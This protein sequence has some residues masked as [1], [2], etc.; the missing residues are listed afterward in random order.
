MVGYSRLIELDEAGTLSRQKQHMIELIKPSIE[1]HS[2]TIVKLTGDG[3]IAEF[4]SVVEAVQCAVEVQ[5]EMLLREENQPEDVRI[6][7]RTAVNLGDIVYEDGDIFGDG[8]NIAARLEELAE[9]GGVVVSG[10][11][12]DLL[13][14]NIDTG[15]VSLGTKRLKNISAPVRVYQ[16]LAGNSSKKAAT[17]PMRPALGA[18]AL[19]AVLAGSIWYF[20]E[21]IGTEERRAI[22]DKP[23]LVVL[24]LDNMTEDTS[25]N[26]FA[27]G[28]SEDLT[29]DLSRH[30]SLFV[31]ARNSAFSTA[32]MFNDPIDAAR[33][34]NVSY[35]VEGS[36]RRVGETLR[37]NVQLIDSK[38]G[39][40]VWAKRYDGTPEDVLKFME[41]VSDEVLVALEI[42]DEEVSAKPLSGQTD[43]PRAFDAFLEGREHFLRQTPE[44]F[45]EAVSLFKRALELDPDYGQARA[46][47]AL[48]YLQ[49][50]EKR[51]H[52]PLGYEYVE[53]RLAMREAQTQVDI[54]MKNPTGLAHQVQAHLFRVNGRPADMLR[55]AQAA[56]EFEPGNPES[57][58]ALSLALTLNGQPNEALGAIE[59]AMNLNPHYPA[60]Y[61]FYQGVALF[62]LKRYEDALVKLER[63]IARNPVDP[64]PFHWK[65]ATHAKMGNL[66]EAEQARRSNPNKQTVYSL[67]LYFPYVSE[68][69]WEHLAEGLRLAGYS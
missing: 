58:A 25:Q 6:H 63:A 14:N 44:D 29:T 57:H 35:V 23:S 47:L 24:P 38:S 1:R 21:P 11:A 49:A 56:V 10:T 64:V 34:L 51:W 43:N 22:T 50:A 54:A 36:V 48:T 26:W 5:K 67:R 53:S 18:L 15:Y 60:Y 13:K 12:Y 66:A 62:D 4:S 55:E 41:S 52:Q 37:I 20:L 39:G 69:T 28:L 7:Y 16:V 19:I 45:V 32:E 31:I 2:G 8:V 46:A 30:P 9:P 65:A 42:T 3:L 17:W 59:Q 33:A 61:L 40:N 27:N 68:G